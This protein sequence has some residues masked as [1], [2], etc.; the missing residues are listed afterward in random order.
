MRKYF[1]ILSLI[2]GYI[3]YGGGG[4]EEVRNYDDMQI[5]IIRCEEKE[6]QI[7]CHNFDINQK[8]KSVYIILKCWI[9]VRRKGSLQNKLVFSISS[10]EPI[11][12]YWKDT[13]LE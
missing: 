2:I 5:L 6:Y 8:E 9:Y 12:A 1:I 11:I 4:Y 13:L 10:K 7:Q 3:G